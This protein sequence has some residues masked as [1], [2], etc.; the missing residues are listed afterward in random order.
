MFLQAVAVA[1]NADSPSIRIYDGRGASTPLK[2]IEKM[3]MKPIT[4]MIYNATFDVAISADRGGMIEYWRGP[5][6]MNIELYMRFTLSTVLS[7][8]I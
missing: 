2:V 6:G 1:G 3:H 5:K 7:T 8:S 4:C